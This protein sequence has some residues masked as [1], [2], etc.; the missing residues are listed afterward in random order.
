M[1]IESFKKFKKICEYAIVLILII[2]LFCTYLIQPNDKNRIIEL[3]VEFFAVFIL[4]FFG[5]FGRYSI[6]K[7]NKT[8]LKIKVLLC[9]V[10]GFSGIVISCILSFLFPITNYL[11]DILFLCCGMI[12]SGLLQI[13]EVK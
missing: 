12:F 5:L 9:I 13:D 7:K 2:I 11:I 4:S 3:L 10:I 6:I 1:K 8:I